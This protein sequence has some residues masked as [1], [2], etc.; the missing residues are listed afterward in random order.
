MTPPFSTSKALDN[1][2]LTITTTTPF[3]YKL[4]LDKQVVVDTHNDT[5]S[6]IT[7]LVKPGK[8]ELYGDRYHSAAFKIFWT[9]YTNR[10]SSDVEFLPNQSYSIECDYRFV[11]QGLHGVSRTE[12]KLLT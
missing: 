5:P 12:C 6:I 1:V 2:S 10:I 11:Q 9:P 7:V 8:Y 4:Y 3:P